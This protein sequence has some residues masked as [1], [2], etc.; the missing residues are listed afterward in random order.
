MASTFMGI[1]I[2]KRGLNAHQQALSTTGHNITN[3]D[4]KNYSR[5]RVELQ[6]IDPLYNPATN[7]AQVAG[8][9]GQG[10]EAA[11][12]IRI[13]DHFIDKRIYATEQSK[14]FW[15]LKQK[16]F[17]QIEIA[18]NEPGEESLRTQI[19]RFWQGWQE[20][21]QYP[22]EFSHRELVLSNAKELTFRMRNTFKNLFDLRQQLDMELKV[23]IEDM[24]EMAR[25]ISHLND[26][27][28]KSTA[29]GDR[30]ND[31]LD[32]RDGLIQKLSSLADINV[33]HQDP[34]ETLIFIGSEI[35]VQGSKYFKM[36]VRGNPENEGLSDVIWEKTKQGI[37]FGNGSI[38]AILEMR[39]L[40]LKEN[41]DK[42][43]LLAVNLSDIVNEVH[44]DGFGLNKN[45][46]IDFF[47]LD[48]LS[49]KTSGNFDSNGDGQDDITALFKIAGRNELISDRPLGISGYL[50]FYKNDQ[51]NTP[52]RIN[53]NEN[54]T[55]E[56]VI[57]RINRSGAGIVSYVNHNDNLVL[58]S[59]LAENSDNQ[60]FMIRHIEDSGELLVGYA[61][62]LQNSGAAGAFDYRRINEIRR[63]QSD[64]DRITLTPAKNPSGLLKVNSLVENNVAFIATARGKDVGGTGDVNQANGAK[65]GSNALRIAQA[66]RHK[67]T[68]IGHHKNVDEFYN[69][70]ISKLGVE[71]KVATDEVQNQGLILTN[72]ENLRQSV[73]GVNLDEE[74]ANMVQFQHGYNASAKL[75]SI[76]DEMLDRIINNL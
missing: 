40:V 36:S 72:L 29:L 53:Y 3:A 63:F 66:L 4:N 19:D 24:N 31:L 28:Q 56:E 18:Y 47:Q 54:E 41:I 52:I 38:R 59:H 57:L 7:R 33:K 49:K 39:D 35:L 58:K 71:S 13:R 44:R 73:M 46:N 22:E 20:L 17:N 70:L 68:M 65:D 51:Q 12:I 1:E 61:G 55:L 15:K 14:E 60:N 76:M 37:I 23:V 67:M 30:P 45:T 32:R 43:N 11:A 16:Y 6:T 2:G 10:V 26:R 74:M 50:T 64:L 21:S 69:S 48:T 75:I 34:D 62:I 42:M 8:N 9:I 5:Q 25:Q 27:I